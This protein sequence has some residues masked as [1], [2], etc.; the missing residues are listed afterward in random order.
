MGVIRADAHPI[1]RERRHQIFPV[2][3]EADLARIARFA[4]PRRFHR[5]ELLKRSG[6]RAAGL[7]VVTGGRVLIQ[8]RDS[9]GRLV[10]IAEHGVGEFMGE[11]GE[12]EGTASFTDAQA[13]EEVE[14]LLVPTDRISALIVGEAVLGERIMRALILRRAVLIDSDSTGPILISRPNSSHLSRLRDFLR[15]NALPFQNLSLDSPNATTLLLEQ[16]GATEDDVTVICPNGAV[17]V[18]PGQR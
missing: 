12:L 5:G 11:I 10:P 13:I 6:E 2:L 4:E 14:A 9:T 8:R 17:L 15:R 7:F 3:V 1:A 18:N 16:Y